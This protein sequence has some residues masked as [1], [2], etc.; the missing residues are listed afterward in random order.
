[1][2]PMAS[3]NG[4]TNGHGG[5]SDRTRVLL[6]KLEERSKQVRRETR[7][8]AREAEKTLLGWIVARMAT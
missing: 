8:E 4:D 6:T 1:M 2:A 7:R 5:L 3:S